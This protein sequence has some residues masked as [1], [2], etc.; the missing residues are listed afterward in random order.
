MHGAFCI[1]MREMRERRAVLVAALVA[2]LLPFAS[3]LLP[4]IREAQIGEARDA[5]AGFLAL[6]LG[7][8]LSVL[9]GATVVAR[10]L[11]ENRLGFDF[12]RPVAALSIWGGRLGSA[13]ALTVAAIAL[14]VIPS[15]LVSGQLVF[16]ERIDEP[17]ALAAALVAAILLLV[18]LAHFAGVAF[19]SRSRW[20]ALDL[21][22]VVV[23]L[24]I[25]IGGVQ[26]IYE[27]FAVQT[28]YF[29]A[30]AAGLAA[31]PALWIASA[32]QVTRGRTDLVA[33]HRVQSLT[34]WSILLVV[35]LAVLGF[36][37]W[38]V[39]AD[40]DDL[41]AAR[42]EP[43]PAGPWVVLDGLAAGR[44]GLEAQFLLDTETGRSIRLGPGDLRAGNAT[45]FS[46]D[47]QRAVWLHQES[48]GSPIVV[49][50]IDLTSSDAAFRQ[51][52]IAFDL[53]MPFRT[54][55]SP[56]GNCL[57]TLQGRSLAVH[58][59]DTGRILAAASLHPVEQN[60]G[61]VRLT[62]VD[63]GR[64]RAYVFGER[65]VAHELN[66]ERRELSSWTGPPVSEGYP[67]IH[68][69]TGHARLILAD[70]GSTGIVLLDGA[71]GATL[72]SLG[73]GEP[74]PSV[75]SRFLADGR[76]VLIAEGSP[77][78]ATLELYSGDG[79]PLSSFD[80]GATDPRSVFWLGAEAAPGM[81]LVKRASRGD[82]YGS[83][84]KLVDLVTGRTRDVAG[85]GVPVAAMSWV[86]QHRPAEPGSVGARL[87]QSARGVWLLEPE[88][89]S[90]RFLAGHPGRNGT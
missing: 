69:Q 33:G 47:G 28:A 8:I 6:G 50:R 34:L 67:E 36:S 77:G 24:V 7:A 9:L 16:L 85:E 86:A 58:D 21:V 83:R 35:A 14:V 31:I 71:N 32:I 68:W 4:G 78:R 30:S 37:L 44:P 19:R 88:T 74:L 52:S 66:V 12:A 48:Y 82:A 57:A 39:A 89:A 38:F 43:A 18:G 23:V 70:P 81:L 84:L 54:A 3:P 79:E 59:L 13:L 53:T 60:W 46:G 72:R 27:A 65:L 22:G 56:S 11:A 15:A 25:T 76:I 45:L 20:L 80:L 42:G 75:R 40:V 73:P 87:V 2:G 55:L 49:E 90:L 26:R 61:R 10:D 29:V 5:M 63:D 51:T 64:V 17:W 62:F 41:Y 1:A